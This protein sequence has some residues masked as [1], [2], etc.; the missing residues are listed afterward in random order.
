MEV[1]FSRIISVRDKKLARSRRKEA[2]GNARCH[3]A[4]KSVKAARQ[5]MDQYADEIRHLEVRMIS[6]LMDRK[7]TLQDIYAIEAKLKR[8]AAQAN[9]LSE[10]YSAAKEFLAD[11]ETDLSILRTQRIASQRELQ[12]ISELDKHISEA[13]AKKRQQMEDAELSEFAEL[14]HCK[15]SF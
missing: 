11:T 8:V 15:R 12:K 6:N 3:A 1:D 4:R 5:A 13:K 14:L 7:I 2:Q 10:Q 9:E